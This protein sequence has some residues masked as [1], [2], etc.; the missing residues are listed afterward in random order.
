MSFCLD[1][2]ESIILA[3]SSKNLRKLTP[4]LFFSVW[5]QKHYDKGR[6]TRF[7]SLFLSSV[8]PGEKI[9]ELIA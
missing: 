2:D 6:K 9:L 1:H 7:I 5:K 3:N 8:S 4:L